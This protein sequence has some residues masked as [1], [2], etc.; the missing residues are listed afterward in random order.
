MEHGTVSGVLAALVLVLSASAGGEVGDW[1]WQQ[2]HAK[3]V[4]S[5]DLQ[6][7]PHSF[8]FEAGESVRYI[9][10]EGGND[11]GAG[12]RDAPWKH[13]PWDANA[14][15]NASECQ[16][17]HTYVFKR[18]VTYRGYLLADD[19]GRAG[20]PIR[21][22][23][24]PTWG[25]G[26]AAF[27]GSVQV[28]AWKR[29]DA[30][31]APGFPDPEK[32]WYA[33]LGTT[34]FP[35]SVWEVRDG[36]VLRV[37]LARDPNWSITNPDDIK[38][39]WYEWRQVKAEDVP[40]ENDQ[41]RKRSWGFDRTH[42]NAE[43]ADAYKGG[44]VWTEYA[45][46][47]G[48]PYPAPI[49]AFDPQRGG[50]RFAG[51]WGNPEGRVPVQY[52]RYFLE[53]LPRFLDA[54]GEHY[55][56]AE[57]PHAGRLYV[58]LKG[59]RDP[60]TTRVEAA[61]R[62]CAIDI[63][64]CSHVHVTGLT[65]RFGNVAHWHDRWWTIAEEDG[66][67]IRILGSGVDL[68]VANCRFEHVAMG[69]RVLARGERGLDDIVVSDSEFLH[70]D[71]GAMDLSREEG[72]RDFSG[73]LRRVSVL[74][75]RLY[76][77][78]LRPMRA[79]HGHALKVG[80]ATLAE[81]AG[82]VLDRVYGAGLFI[83]GGK[84]WGQQS[85]IPLTR[86]LIHHNKV[87]D[88]LLNSNDWGGVETWQGGPFYTYNNVS[89][90]PGGYWHW[91]HT[92]G[93]DPAKR[94]H[95]TARFGFAYYLDGSFKNYLFNN[96]AWGKSNDLT[97]PLANTT[98]LQEIIGFFNIFANNTFYKFVAGTRRQI[99]QAGRDAYL[100]N[101]W[102][103]ISEMFFRHSDLRTMKD[104]TLQGGG[105]DAD[106]DTLAYVR[107]L[108][109][110]KPRTFG[111]FHTT[112]PVHENLDAY[113]DALKKMDARGSQ[114]GWETDR[115]PFRDAE[116]HDFRL[117]SGSEAI[118]RGVRFFAPW[119]L[120]ATVG[121]WNFCRQPGD[122]SR[123][124]DESWYMT[125][126]HTGRD[127]YRLIPHHDLKAHGVTADSYVEGPLEDWASG[128]LTL[129]GRDQ[130]CVLKDA[131]TRSD[132]SVGRGKTFPGE[133]RKTFNIDAGNF[134][135]EAYL[136]TPDGQTDGSIASKMDETGYVL[137]L[138][139]AGRPR[140]TLTW[141][142]GRCGR[143][144]S[145]AINDGAWHHVV[146]EVD[147]AANQGIAIYV[148]GRKA[149]GEWTGQMPPKDAALANHADFL[150]GRS[151]EGDFLAATFDFLRVCR[152]TLADARTSIEELYA[153]QFDGP[154]LRDFAGQAPAGQR[155]DAGAIEHAD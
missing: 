84:G 119:G 118:D 67:A 82:N 111:H 10:Y 107:N 30:D 147:R 132:Y 65:F 7:A 116:K 83:F 91:A 130:Y 72:R 129:N 76:R 95:T 106:Y 75:N 13:H 85:E 37:A 20:N 99:P 48:T 50:I 47:M 127:M 51:P 14:Q 19:S 11:A 96:I 140:L 34:F 124:L 74:R 122:P 63:R 137:D 142:G 3:V 86:V 105:R 103:D 77:I 53:N 138:D 68:R 33:D 98:G 12:T 148:D 110:G 108:F 92:F 144:A 9:D 8:V 35:R 1:S 60:N 115:S 4:P 44:T 87:T 49:E 149:S 136:K 61:Q 64:D 125:A 155:R 146:A 45:G 139:D 79:A 80:F 18:G 62:V 94:T 81:V 97:S 25:Q 2:S 16:G 135:I 27:S 150:V 23:S 101:I 145:K 104:K 6:W 39:Q 100:G 28:A 88:C 131:D 123:L 121:E 26:E 141:D 38:S 102:M 43:D 55:Y 133:R 154:F 69:V 46:V 73:E 31:S 41:T 78:G 29:A 21:L 54:P 42:L 36:E 70:T 114:V 113:R 112:G 17:V 90:N 56:A 5:G 120:Y 117:A 71:Y 57:G 153:W 58:R 15:G 134:L 24:D 93:T 22:T 66:A 126:E 89:G 128:A 143:V 40:G 59:D 109:V 152:G 52:C 151:A 32:I